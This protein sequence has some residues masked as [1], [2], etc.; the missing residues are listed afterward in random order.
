[1]EHSTCQ[2]SSAY[3]ILPSINS[4]LMIA[5]DGYAYLLY[6]YTLGSGGQTCQPD[7]I[8]EACAPD[9]GHIEWHGRLLRLGTGGDSSEIVLGDASED[10]TVTSTQFGYM[11][12]QAGQI[13]QYDGTQ[14]LITNADQGVLLSLYAPATSYCAFVQL[15]GLDANGLPI[16]NNSGCVDGTFNTQLVAA[17]RFAAPIA[18]TVGIHAAAG[19]G[20]ADAL[21]LSD[22][23]CF[24]LAVV[25][26]AIFHGRRQ[27][28]CFPEQGC[29]LRLPRA[30]FEKTHADCFRW[31]EA[32][33]TP[34]VLWKECGD[35]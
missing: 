6:S 18:P 13:P 22:G 28:L 20:A 9:S 21:E 30:C 15:V 2:A 19:S 16:Y 14:I 35:D 5:G 31:R 29:A 27:S 1:M 11:G 33:P 8:I 34:G 12:T 25:P 23:A 17:P 4:N 26:H 32:R 3:D 7:C 24:V 10:W